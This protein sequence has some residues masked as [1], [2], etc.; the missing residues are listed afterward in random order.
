[1]EIDLS[2]R[3]VQIKNI[4]FQDMLK[5]DGIDKE[6]TTKKTLLLG[7]DLT[8]DEYAK[9]EVKDGL[10]LSKAINEQNGFTEKAF[11]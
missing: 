5:L 10:A 4:K 6:L 2:F 1:M 9:L 11:Q 8:E 3:K 7:S